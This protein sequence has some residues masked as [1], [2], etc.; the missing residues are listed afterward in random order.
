MGLFFGLLAGDPDVS[1]ISPAFARFQGFTGSLN[2]RFAPTVRSLFGLSRE[3]QWIFGAAAEVGGLGGFG[4]RDFT[5]EN[6][7]NARAF[8]MG[9]HHDFIGLVVGGAEHRLK[10]H[11]DKLARGKIIVEQQ[12]FV[13]ARLVD[14]QL[15]LEFRFGVEIAHMGHY[16]PGF[17]RRTLS[18]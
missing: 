13:H 10:H 11:D 15:W 8:L 2:W 17:R 7:D 9:G 5:R 12:H 16:W 4:F 18:R 3:R 1:D 14:L 6:R